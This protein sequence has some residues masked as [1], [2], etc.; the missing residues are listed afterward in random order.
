MF[1]Q[2]AAE[3]QDRLSCEKKNDWTDSAVRM[4]CQQQTVRM[5][6]N[7]SRGFVA[8]H[9]DLLTLI[10]ISLYIT[11]IYLVIY[12]CLGTWVFFTCY[13]FIIL[14]AGGNK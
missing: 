4:L 9:L 8:P 3:T 2:A 5:R 11:F 1:L 6:R 14:H 10:K 7:K 13:F 12:L